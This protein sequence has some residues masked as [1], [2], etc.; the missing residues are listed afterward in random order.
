L[1]P[2]IRRNQLILVL[3]SCLVTLSALR[4][5]RWRGIFLAALS[6]TILGCS[7]NV[8]STSSVAGGQLRG[9]IHGGQQPVSGASVQLY[10]A[11]TTGY[12][13][14]A[15]ALLASP[16]MSDASGSFTITGDYTCPSS[17][18]EL[19]LVA[20]GG[21]PGLGPGT[22]NAALAMMTALGPCSLHG[23]QYTLDPN[24]FIVI[25]EATTVASVYALAAFMGADATH[26]GTSGTN[27]VGLANSFQIV[28]NLVNT[29]TGAALATT[30]AGNGIAPQATINTLGNVL[31]SCVNSDGTGTPCGALFAA[32]RPGGGTAPTDT[33]QAVYDIARNPVNNVSTL[34]GLGSAT[35]PFQ[36]TLLTAPNDWV[37][38]V[39]YTGGGLAANQIAIDALGNAW[40]ANA[41]TSTGPYSVAELSSNGAILSGANGYTGGGLS[42][43]AGIAIDPAGNAWVAGAG[44]VVKFSNSG[45]ILSGASGFTGG[46][47]NRPAAIALDGQGNAWIPDIGS[48][49][50]IK[51]DNN[52]NILS[53]SSGFQIG[54]PSIPYGL[55]ID[56]A[57]DAWVTNG[58]TTVTE[59][60]NNGIVISGSTGYSVT[61]GIT[62]SEVAFDPSGNAWLNTGLNNAG[63]IGELDP[64]GVQL[65]PSTGYHDCVSPGI[66]GGLNI[67]CLWQNPDAFALDGAG[68]FWGEVVWET[69]VNGR[70]PDP[71]TSAGVAVMSNTGTILSGARGFTGSTPMGTLIPLIGGT[72][73]GGGQP[74]AIAIDG[75]GNVWM[76][77]SDSD[78]AVFIGAATPVVTPFSLGVRNGTLGQ[79]P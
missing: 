24:A 61:G 66:V 5:K 77:Y 15:T 30:P 46:G 62:T 21:N 26:L 49:S 28:N 47:L 35:P 10:A 74:R 57:G 2:I 44:N 4:P 68:N 36:P 43:P 70:N 51:L 3:R 34:Y 76:L 65:S 45:T 19:Y 8:P 31:A 50:V 39:T 12:G 71:M 54:R 22:N 14:S 67:Q 13:V 20:T 42:L 6:M 75:G 18:S 7:A 25:N 60:N 64:N 33:I 9:S 16:V 79:R 73:G 37:M 55:A 23:S 29:S 1:G 53:G 69:S 38:A 32:A 11:G 56:R 58:D 41:V 72:G 48:D 63:P 52:G 59:F 27:A 78:V 17:S 40:F